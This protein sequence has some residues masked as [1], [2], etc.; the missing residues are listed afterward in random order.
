MDFGFNLVLDLDFMLNI[1]ISIINS[2][3]GSLKIVLIGL[4][5]Y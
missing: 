4:A 2:G 5:K 3:E 1:L